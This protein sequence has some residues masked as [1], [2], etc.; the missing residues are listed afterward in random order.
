MEEIKQPQEMGLTFKEV[1]N[2][3]KC[4]RVMLAVTLIVSVL[5]SVAVL[6]I[7]REGLGSTSYETEITFSSASISEENEFNP[8]T[9]TNTLLKSNAVVTA[10]LEKCGYSNEEQQNLLKNGLVSELSAY[11]AVETTSTNGVTYPYVVK[12]SLKKTNKFKLSK[13]QATEL[14]EIELENGKFI[15]C[16]PDH[17]ILTERGWI[18]AG[19]L[20]ETDTIKENM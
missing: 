2:L 1:F 12:L 3:L 18:E 5:L 13:A 7:A 11:T 8:S 10:A 17:L 6:V 19:E 4:G 16:T 14:I 20:N 9:T 15:R